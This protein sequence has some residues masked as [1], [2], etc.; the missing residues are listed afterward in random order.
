MATC[1]VYVLHFCANACS[2]HKWFSSYL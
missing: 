1:N 2:V